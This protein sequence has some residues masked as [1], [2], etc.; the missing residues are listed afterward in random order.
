MRST[1]VV[2][3]APRASLAEDG[4]EGLAT[5]LGL[6]EGSRFLEARRL[7]PFKVVGL[8]FASV[9]FLETAVGQW[10]GAATWPLLVV[11]SLRCW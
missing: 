8:A 10:P 6:L 2:G 7:E 5:L 3:A 4:G 11:R 9:L 1:S